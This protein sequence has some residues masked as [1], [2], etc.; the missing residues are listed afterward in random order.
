[1]TVRVRNGNANAAVQQPGMLKRIWKKITMRGGDSTEST[2]AGGQ[3]GAKSADLLDVTA[4][5]AD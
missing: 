3:P 4:G 1:M 5:D 2:I